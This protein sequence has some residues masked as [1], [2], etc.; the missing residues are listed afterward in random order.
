MIKMNENKLQNVQN[1]R[2]E[3]TKEIFIKEAKEFNSDEQLLGRIYDKL[4]KYTKDMF[5]HAISRTYDLDSRIE[6]AQI[7]IKDLT[8]TRMEDTDKEWETVLINEND[9]FYLD[10]LHVLR[11]NMSLLSDNNESFI[12]TCI[13]TLSYCIST[14]V[15]MT[16][17]AESINI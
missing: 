15:N 12:D 17:L 3:S 8:V 9:V 2:E 13:M 14:Y 4:D 10:L 6:K 1:N 16:H 11:S 7:K 5:I